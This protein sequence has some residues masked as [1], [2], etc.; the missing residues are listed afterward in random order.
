MLI[1]PNVARYSVNGRYLGNGRATSTII[2]LEITNVVNDSRANAVREGALLVLLSWDVTIRGVQVDEWQAQ[3][4][5]FVDM[6]SQNGAT[7]IESSNGWPVNGGVAGEAVAFN[8]GVLVRKNL[9]GGDR[10]RRA[11]RWTLPGVPEAAVASGYTLQGANLGQWQTEVEDFLNAV[12]GLMSWN[13]ASAAA[14]VAMCV[15]HIT[16]RDAEGNPVAGD[17]RLVESLEVQ[18]ILATQRRRLRG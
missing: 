14:D 13:G 1:V 9:L 7:G 15:T 16:G 8:T 2:D 10:S 17:Y 3:S 5:S 18:P 4:V 6:D 12:N 11:G